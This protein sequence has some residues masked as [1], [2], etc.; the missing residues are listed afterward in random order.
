MNSCFEYTCFISFVIFSRKLGIFLRF[1]TILY[2]IDL[3]LEG[4]KETDKVYRYFY[5]GFLTL[6]IYFSH[7]T[8]ITLYNKYIYIRRKEKRN[9]IIKKNH[10]L[11]HSTLQHIDIFSCVRAH[12]LF[13]LYPFQLYIKYEIWS[14]KYKSKC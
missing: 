11:L 5:T 14:K 4:R 2:L 8:N 12:K 6:C 9:I 3:Y 1:L 13:S 7:T 10:I